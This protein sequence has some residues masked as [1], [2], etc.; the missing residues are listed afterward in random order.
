M[1]TSIYF[2]NATTTRPSEKTIAKMMPFFRE[3]WGL[4]SSPHVK[5][6]EVYFPIEE[7][8]QSIYTLIDAKAVDNFVFTSS[9]TEAVNQVFQSVYH[10]VTRLTGKNQF[11]TSNIEEAPAMMAIARLEELTCVGKMVKANPAGK[12]TAKAIE[13]L[14]TPRTALV[15]VSWANAL[16]GVINPVADISTVCQERGVL[17][18][19]EATHVLGKLFYQLEDI[20][21]SFLTFNGDQLHAPK[22]TGGLYIKQGVKSSP[23]LVGSMDQGGKRAGSYNVP[24]LIGLGEAAKEALEARDYLCTEVARLR[25][26]FETEVASQINECT[27][28][29]QEQDRLPH[30]S[31]ISFAGI[32]NEALLYALNRKGVYASI[33]GGNFQQIGLILMA[34]GVNEQQAHSALSFSFSR[35]TTEDEVLRAVNIIKECVLK[36]RKISSQFF[37]KAPE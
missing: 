14:L 34:C 8:V 19:I 29:F 21:P 1:T 15:S 10:D 13:E 9:G 17:L 28:F 33:G 30:I 18:H 6:H 20:G 4:P 32:A 7:S 35:E 27:F 12:I 16:T 26:L 2:D 31:A 24:G 11:I 22:G 23:L 25:D 36:L 37:I 5:G 3:K